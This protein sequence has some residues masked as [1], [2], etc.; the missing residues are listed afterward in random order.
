MPHGILHRGRFEAAVHHAVG[1]LFVI[2]GAVRVPVGFFH[3][4]A[5]RSRVAFAEQIAG[6]L[7]AEH[8]A[9]R[10]APRRAAVFLVAG[11]EI[12]EQARL[13]ERPRRAAAAATEDVAKEL[14]GRRAMRKCAWSGA[15]SY[16]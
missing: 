3:Q 11:Q 6:T 5:K 14:L 9:R 10:I 8:G 4:L 2:A 7:P 12:E 16:A 15:R 13:A 1:A